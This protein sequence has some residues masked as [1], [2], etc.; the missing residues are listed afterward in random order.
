MPDAPTLTVLHGLRLGSVVGS[1][2]LARRTGLPVEEVRAVL[3]TAN[4]RGWVRHSEG[5]LVG[6]SLTRG[7]RAEGER[8]LA[9]QLDATGNRSQV[10]AVHRDFL[11]L[12]TTVL[13]VCTEWQVVRRDGAEVANDHSDAAH[14]AAVLERLALAHAEALPLLGRLAAALDRFGGYA[15]RLGHALDR[16]LAGRT[17]WFTRPTIDSYHS[18]WFELH[19][20]LLATLGRRRTD[21]RPGA[22]RTELLEEHA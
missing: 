11:P 10:E 14:D 2:D 4:D 6:W 19:E 16:T 3:A 9:L 21:E 15:D 18:V 17:E 12:N 8:L 13:R 7:G 20:D 22:A 5:R 1:E